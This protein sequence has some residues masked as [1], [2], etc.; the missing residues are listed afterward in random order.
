[1]SKRKL[2]LSGSSIVELRKE[3]IE[4]LKETEGMVENIPCQPS[5]PYSRTATQTR[6]I[7]RTGISDVPGMENPFGNSPPPPNLELANPSLGST[8]PT[9]PTL[10]PSI[11]PVV[12][13]TSMTTATQDA[14]T[15][16][17]GHGTVT[18]NITD[19][20]GR[21]WDERIHSANQS[22]NSDGS[23]RYKRGV[24]KNL[25]A[26][27][28]NSVQPVQHSAPIAPTTAPVAPTLAVVPTP[29]VV[30]PVA[31]PSLAPVQPTPVAQPVA[32]VVSPLRQD[33][34]VMPQPNMAPAHT[35]ETFQANMPL[36]IAGLVKE[37]KL[38]QEYINA[39]LRHCN[40][41]QLWEMNDVQVGQFFDML[42]ANK[43]IIKVQ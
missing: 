11:A 33:S 25:V 39:V 8:A 18:P 13:P 20:N 37:G 35:V 27:I 22:K 23:W 17:A 30:S 31:P 3:C 40:V 21:P 29:E 4:F 2:L 1:V 38:T 42:V 32:P 36:V 26:Q 15:T 6:E 24:D 9:A 7:E 41:T 10:A 5:P 14:T 19:S 34:P 28:E 12:A 16:S 43:L